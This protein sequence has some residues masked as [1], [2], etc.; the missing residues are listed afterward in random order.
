MTQRE[1]RALRARLDELRR[2]MRP[3]CANCREPFVQARDPRT[4]LPS[5]HCWQSNCSCYKK[6]IQVHLG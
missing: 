5:E 6:T 2:T 3:R 4:G 1:N